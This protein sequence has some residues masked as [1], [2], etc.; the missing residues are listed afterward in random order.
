MPGFTSTYSS[1]HRTWEDADATII[2]FVES[3]SRNAEPRPSREDVLGACEAHSIDCKI[4]LHGAPRDFGRTSAKIERSSVKHEVVELRISSN[5]SYIF[6]ANY[7]VIFCI[8]ELIS[9]DEIPIGL[10]DEVTWRPY[11]EFQN[12]NELVNGLAQCFLAQ[13]GIAIKFTWSP[14]SCRMS[15]R[16]NRWSMRVCSTVDPGGSRTPLPLINRV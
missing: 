13:D 11:I 12:V 1:K 9:F 3:C 14:V 5:V 6:G 10:H 4:L 8:E 2:K 15:R 7:I 16:G